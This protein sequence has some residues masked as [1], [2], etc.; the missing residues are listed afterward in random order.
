MFSC[1]GRRQ[2]GPV[3]GG[4]RVLIEALRL[5]PGLYACGV[6]GTW[7]P[8]RWASRHA[9]ECNT[10]PAGFGAS[11]LEVSRD[12]VTLKRVL[13]FSYVVAPRLL[14][15]H[16]RTGPQLGAACLLFQAKASRTTRTST[17]DSRGPRCCIVGPNSLALA[18]D[19]GLLRASLELGRCLLSY[20][21]AWLTTHQADT[22][23]RTQF[24]SSSRDT[25]CKRPRG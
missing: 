4:T 19:A 20:H 10:G 9:L 11:L 6:G 1:S 23:T 14:R 5:I 22:H 15:M 3:K 8:A 12:N 2:H 24:R 21:L 7:T 17:A 13:S 25:T 18:R 16:P